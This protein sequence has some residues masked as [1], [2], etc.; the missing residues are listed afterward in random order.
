MS[1]EPLKRQEIAFTITTQDR[2]NLT[3][4]M[5]D[6]ITPDDVFIHLLKREAA[7]VMTGEDQGDDIPRAFKDFLIKQNFTIGQ[8]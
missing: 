7:K 8:N 2:G 1:S 5:Y 3:F 4:T 6:R